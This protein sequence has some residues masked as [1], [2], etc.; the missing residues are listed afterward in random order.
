MT[1]LKCCLLYTSGRY[2][3]IYSYQWE[4]D[5]FGVIMDCT[6]D[7][8]KNTI[9]QNRLEQIE[10]SSQIDTLTNIYNRKG[11]ESHVRQYFDNHLTCLLYTSRCV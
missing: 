4:D 9:L 8:H 6:K 11:F 1:Y 3:S 5:F 7:I 2:L 10:T